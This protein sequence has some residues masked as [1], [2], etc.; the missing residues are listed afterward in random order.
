MTK[1]FRKVQVGKLQQRDGKLCWIC[2]LPTFEWGSTRDCDVRWWATRD[3]VVP[4]KLGGSD[5]LDNLKVAHNFCNG[6]RGHQPEKFHVFKLKLFRT[7]Y[8]LFIKSTDV[9][10]F[11][12]RP[13]Q[14]A[15]SIRYTGITVQIR[16]ACWRKGW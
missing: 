13:R 14:Y 3:H 15:G 1:Q 7:T 6:M 8:V 2:G 16:L 5:E 4:K 9:R 12:R 10:T 11:T